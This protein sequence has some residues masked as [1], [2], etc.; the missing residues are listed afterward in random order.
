MVIDG[1]KFNSLDVAQYRQCIHIKQYVYKLVYACEGNRRS[2]DSAQG[3]FL[4]MSDG[5]A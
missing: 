4:P 1:R 2:V 5:S 3:A